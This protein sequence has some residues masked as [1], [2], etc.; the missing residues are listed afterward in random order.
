MY[1]ICARM[2]Q[3]MGKCCLDQIF[4]SLHQCLTTFVGGNS[5]Y[6]HMDMW[7]NNLIRRNRHFR[8]LTFFHG[9]NLSLNYQIGQFSPEAFLFGSN[10]IP[11]FVMW[12]VYM[13]CQV[14][15]VSL[16]VRLSGSLACHLGHRRPL[17]RS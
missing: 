12:H 6:S 10:Y 8:P 16:N 15:Y 4:G 17:K 7:K 11:G 3:W 5:A 14:I 9:S 13:A 1:L 2:F